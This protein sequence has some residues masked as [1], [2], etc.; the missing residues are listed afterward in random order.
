MCYV[1]NLNDEKGA[2]LL[3]PLIGTTQ[4]SE[5]TE[6]LFIIPFNGFFTSINHLS[7]SSENEK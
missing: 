3:Q 7:V 5:E 2:G 4:C 1:I 6:Q